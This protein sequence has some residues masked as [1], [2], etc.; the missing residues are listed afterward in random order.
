M[1]QLHELLRAEYRRDRGHRVVGGRS[2]D[3]LLLVRARVAEAQLE[4]EAVE[5]CFGERVRA[6]LLDG[7]LRGEHEEWLRE[8]VRLACRRHRVLLHGLQEGG[9]RLGRRAVDLVGE[10]RV[11]EDGTLHVAEGPAP[12]GLVLFHQLGA[13]DVARHQV[14]R[15]LD[16]CEREIER[17]GHRSDQQRLGEPRYADE[18]RVSPAQQRGDEV[19]DYVLLPDDA[20]RDLRHEPRAR[21]R[22]LLQQLHVAHPS[23]CPGLSSQLPIPTLRTSAKGKEGGEGRERERHTVRGPCAVPC[24]LLPAPCSLLPAPCSLLPTPCSLLPAPCFLLPAPCSLLPAPCFLSLTRVSGKSRLTIGRPG[25]HGWGGN[26][27]M[28]PHIF[29]YCGL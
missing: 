7:V 11:G 17:L 12:G 15:E 21:L 24:S 23:R 8:S 1:L 22:E 29:C 18:Q 14:G 16:A 19:V 27:G 6:L 5:L 2:D 28:M 20:P 13:R 3:S 25:Q 4:H 10:H 26:V 9:L